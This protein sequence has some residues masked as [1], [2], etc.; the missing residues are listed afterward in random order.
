[1]RFVLLRKAPALGLL[2]GA[3]LLGASGARAEVPAGIDGLGVG[4]GIALTSNYIYRGV[5]ESDGHGAL[6]ADLHLAT[7]GGTFVGTWASSRDGDLEP[8]AA[9]VLEVYLGHRFDLSSTWNAT[10][11]ARSHYYPGGNT[12]EPSDDY[13]EISGALTYLDRWSVSITAIPNAVRYWLYTRL[14]RRPAWVADVSG[15]W[16]LGQHFFVTG[17]AGYY[18]STGTGP[19]ME[20]ATGYA[21][22]NLGVAYEVRN[23]RLDVGYYLTQD[24]AR[25]SFPYPSASQQIAVTLAWHF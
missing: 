14:G 10:V 23:W 17:G 18:Y 19:A 11:T 5:S 13:Q 21:Y 1:M 9:T 8:G 2:A 7:T 12:Y 6:Q 4:G 22:G 25:R 24:A 16:L 15:Q 3:T 20:R